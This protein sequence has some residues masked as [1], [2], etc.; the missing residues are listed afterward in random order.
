MG[1]P[2]EVKVSAVR[3]RPWF[4][5]RGPSRT[6]LPGQGF[7]SPTGARM[8]SRA[9]RRPGNS[10]QPHRDS[11]PQTPR[12]LRVSAGIS[13]DRAARHFYRGSAKCQQRRA[14]SLAFAWRVGS[15]APPLKIAVSWVRVPVSPS[16]DQGRSEFG[17]GMPPFR[18]KP[19]GIPRKP[20]ACPECSA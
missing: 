4:S 5:S 10:T 14:F 20:T 18:P 7:G 19:P 17:P 9:L 12:H 3:V 16:A 15:V 11:S 1:V 6:S 8:S 13:A 2:P